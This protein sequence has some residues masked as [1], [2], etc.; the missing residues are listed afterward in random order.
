MKLHKIIVLFL[1][2][3]FWFVSINLVSAEVKLP[4]LI[5][6]GLVLQRNAEVKIWGWSSPEENINID[7][8]NTVYKTK[9]NANGKWVFALN[10]LKAGGP[11]VMTISGTNTI[12][13]NNVLVGDVWLCSGQSNMEISMQRVKPLY[14]DDIKSANNPKIHYIEIPKRYNF[15]EPQEDIEAVTWK[16]VNQD[17]IL[18]FSAVAYFFA[19]ELN[20]TYNVPIGIINSS[21]GGAPAESWLSED[22]LKEFPNYYEELQKF[23]NDDLIGEIQNY[24]NQNWKDWH[25]ELFN[26]DLGNKNNPWYSQNIDTTNWDGMEVPGYWDKEK[27]AGKNGV[28]WFRKDIEIPKSML[29]KTLKLNLGRVVDSDSVYVNGTF[30]GTTGYKYPPRRYNIPSNL[31]VEGKNNITVRVINESGDG[32]FYLD[33]PYEI[34]SDDKTIDLKGIWK[35]KLGAEMPPKE[36]QTFIRWKPTG[37]FNAMLSPLLN[38]TIKGAVWYQGEANTKN[39]KEYETLF[40]ALI[41]NWRAKFNQG[42]FP[43]LFVQLPNYQESNSHPTESSWAELR[44]AQL[45]TLSLPNTA[46]AVAIDLGEWNDIHPLNKKDVAKRLVLAARKLAYKEKNIVSSGPTLKG[47]KIKG[48]KIILK[49]DNIGSGLVAKGG[50]LKEFAIAGSDQKFLWAKAVI[51]KN[52]IIVSSE[53]VKNPVAVRYAWADNPDK[54]N[55][56]NKENLPASPFRTDNW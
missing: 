45:K 15:K 40:P 24:D 1:N 6:D 44:D 25:Y 16:E 33:K 42:D 37:L 20:K 18:Q 50:E 5:S 51:K 3:F 53:A 41:K 43:F 10:N 23:K 30:V 54:A 35:Y 38:Y 31:L 17:N 22:A 8:N 13:I 48:N 27:I 7:F 56:Y 12:T 4:S 32:G 34:K 46:M 55:L 47:K 39:P 26:K 28:V 49:F 9:A 2:I 11:Y 19:E 21:L 36:G 52:K 29:N 14:E